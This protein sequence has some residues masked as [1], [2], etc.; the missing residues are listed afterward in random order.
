MTRL[1][2]LL[3][4]TGVLSLGSAVAWWWF[5]YREVISYD[6]ISPKEA[7]LCLIGQ[8]TICDLA[9]AL[10]RGTHPLA[11]IDYR[12]L[13]FWLAIILLSINLIVAGRKSTAF[14]RLS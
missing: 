3:W 4:V 10:C 8:S 6:F 11:I 14:D 12:P 9:R 13:S 1:R 2:C 5:T 7:G